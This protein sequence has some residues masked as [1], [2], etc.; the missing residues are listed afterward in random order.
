ME[1]K[2]RRSNFFAPLPGTT[3]LIAAVLFLILSLFHFEQTIDFHLHD[4]MFVISPNYFCYFLA[5]LCG[6]EFLIYRFLNFLMYKTWISWI[7]VI[8][9]L[10]SLGLFVLP[11]FFSQLNQPPKYV[12]SEVWKKWGESGKTFALLVVGSFLLSLVILVLN[13]TV[14][15]FAKTTLKK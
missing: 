8:L 9:T 14:G 4:T 2:K 15:F 5:I 12:D 1:S 7:Q 6:I 13:I 11:I 10:F 3:F